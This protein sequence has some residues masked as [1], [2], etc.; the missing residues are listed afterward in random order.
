[1]GRENR[2]LTAANHN[3]I[4]QV[5]PW[6]RAIARAVAMGM[7]PTEIAEKYGYTNAH[8]TRIMGSPLFKAEV[9]RLEAQ[10]EIG[11]LNVRG[12]LEQMA[13]RANE[14]LDRELEMDP[15]NLMERRL[16]VGVAQDIL[17][18]TGHGGKAAPSLHLHKHEHREV[19][20]MTDEEL[21]REVMEMA[22]EEEEGA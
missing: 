10:I 5:R 21:Y 18:R 7:R 6:H 14:V 12:E 19:K 8:I 2:G 20:D 17:D 9:A 1:M 16:Q 11:A 3:P 22:Q 4:I 13:P 15:T